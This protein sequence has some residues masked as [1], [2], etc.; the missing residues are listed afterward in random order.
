MAASNNEAVTPVDTSAVDTTAAK[1][2]PTV[3]EHLDFTDV[4]DVIAKI[5]AGEITCECQ[6][7]LAT[8]E[9]HMAAAK[10][11][12]DDSDM[13]SGIEFAPGNFVSN[14]GYMGTGMLGIFI[15][16]ALIMATT[17][18]LNKAFS[19]KKKEDTQE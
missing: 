3:L 14:L 8:L 17:T 9:G 11:G 2:A 7:C 4:S 1:P 5:E 6:E 10:D 16:I 13:L 15:V 18:I 19:G 12:S